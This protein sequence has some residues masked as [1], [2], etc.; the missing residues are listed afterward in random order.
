MC[1]PL[2]GPATLATGLLLLKSPRE[3]LTAAPVR[4]PRWSR[5]MGQGPSGTHSS[6]RPPPAH[7][8][9]AVLEGSTDMG[10]VQELSLTV[11]LCLRADT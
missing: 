10:Q 5:V 8:R 6:Q 1:L 11:F 4:G 2:W 7:S 3:H 9:A